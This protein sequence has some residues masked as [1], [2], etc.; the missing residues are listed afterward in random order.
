[1]MW[2]VGFGSLLWDLQY[3]LKV[4][5]NYESFTPMPLG[6]Y[7]LHCDCFAKRNSFTHGNGTFFSIFQFFTTQNSGVED[8]KNNYKSFLTLILLDDNPSPP[9]ETSNIL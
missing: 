4:V 3:P 8:Y 7:L 2:F 5:H 6:V 9:Y 1:M